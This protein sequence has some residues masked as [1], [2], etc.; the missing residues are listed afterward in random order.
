MSV[1]FGD[2]F[3]SVARA[4]E[5]GA[6]AVICDGEVTTWGDFD[7]RSNA[8]AR[9]LV[10]LGLDPGAK[11]SLYMR[12]GPDYM[13]AFTA[14]LKARLAPV[15]INYRYGVEEVAYLLDN[16]DS[17]VLIFDVEFADLVDQLR[18]K[19]VLDAWIA[20][21]GRHPAAAALSEIYSG[22]DGSRLDLHRSPDDLFLLYTG[23]TTGMPKGVM[24]PS[25][26]L[27]GTL[28]ASRAAR[29]E[30]PPPMTLPDLE[31]QI[32][33]GEGRVRYQIAP[34]LMHGTGLFAALSVMSRGGSIVCSARP[35]FDPEATVAEL[36]ELNCDG[37]VIVG[38]AFARPILDVLRRTLGRYDVSHMKMVVS[39]GMMWSPEVK[40]GLLEFMPDAVMSDG[41][42]A[43]ESAGIAYS[44]VTRDA[45]P[46]E[47]RFNLANAIVL[48][49]DDL[50]PVEPGSGEIGI[51]A[52][53]GDIPLGYYKDP[54]RTA[55]T[56]VS[57]N[58]V[59]HILGG[60]HALV[61]A[62]GSIRLLGRGS[63]CINTAGEKV[64]PEEV[65]EALKTHPQVTDAL[66]FGIADDRFGQSVAAVT[67]IEGVVSE[68]D[69]I[70]HV[71]GQLAPYKAPRTIVAVATVPRAVNGKAD[72]EEARR[73]FAAARAS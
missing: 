69:L 26:A 22:H 7:R 65:E 4:I 42:G 14:A 23:G 60:D 6:P 37:V 3:D 19:C 62:D 10:G 13:V 25:S 28:S 64:Y 40:L 32:R 57:I 5:D 33:S 72:Y 30:D 71:R 47:A 56:Y 24:W 18:S 29:P 8:L 35:S 41:L 11:V 52:K 15:N 55:R 51:I 38:D 12:N 43:S 16:S 61:E 9:Y 49:P 34:P 1:N 70:A 31:A 48:R 59:R 21:R 73:L 45:P 20:A 68:A 66:V 67:A 36:E 2:V 46:S 50:T 17:R 39:S 63:H 54:E 27:W 58:G 44:V 53:S